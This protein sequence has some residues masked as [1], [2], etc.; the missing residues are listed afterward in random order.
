MAKRNKRKQQTQPKQRKQLSSEIA[1]PSAVRN[2]WGVG[3]TANG[4]TPQQLGNIIQCANAGDAEAYLTLA[5]EMEERDLHYSSVLRTRKLAVE[6]LP[7]VVEPFDDSEKERVKAEEIQRVVK[8]A[9]FGDFIADA[10]DAIGKGYSVNEILW[11]HKDDRLTPCKFIYRD[12]KFFMFPFAQSEEL[13][14][15]DESNHQTGLEM[16]PYK[17][18]IHKP[19]LKS[20]VQLRG[21]LARLVSFAYMCKA[22]GVK[23]WLSFLDV[24]GIPLRLGKYDSAA[25]DEDI[26]ILKNAVASIGTDCAA[27]LPESMRIEFEQLTQVNNGSQSFLVLADWIDKQ[28]SKGVLGQTASTEGTAGRLGS[29]DVQETVRQELIA[30]DARQLSN[31]L[32][33][34][35]ARAYIDLNYGTDEPCP[36]IKI[37]VPEK[38]DLETLS[39]NLERLVPLGLKVSMQEIRNKLGLKEPD[40]DAELLTPMQ[41]S[42]GLDVAQNNAQTCSCGKARNNAQA[43]AVPSDFETAFYEQADPVLDKVLALASSVKSY[44]QL[45]ELLPKL[46]DDAEVEQVTLALAKAGMV[47]N[48]QGRLDN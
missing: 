36:T 12:P 26:A 16:P 46:L 22:Y 7:I 38:E 30:A 17:F 13:R 42:N 32:T 45:I 34:D 35:V 44:E 23:D 39:K 27:V 29:D 15:I 24:Y 10:L 8:S 11:E 43:E 20:G 6:S 25:S 48:G 31:T 37:I 4:L 5:E 47:A 18:V 3:S 1:A 28:V 33:R 2:L 40:K 9:A 19:K 41:Q 14:I 21:G